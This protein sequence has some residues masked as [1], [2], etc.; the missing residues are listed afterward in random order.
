MCKPNVEGADCS[1]CKSNHYNLT[2]DNLNGCSNCHCS[3]L[4]T[5]GKIK[6]CNI[7]TGQCFCKELV[8]GKTCGQCTDGYHSLN[9]WN[10]FGCTGK[11]RNLFIT[12][13]NH[14]EMILLSGYFTNKEDP[15]YGRR[16]ATYSQKYNIIN[17]FF[18]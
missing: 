18:I 13:M 8:S 5:H 17:I 6:A 1:S 2:S 12:L 14:A 11:H 4:G 7:Q 9:R 15:E 16:Y 10:L 3:T